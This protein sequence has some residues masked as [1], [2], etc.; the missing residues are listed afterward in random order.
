MRLTVHGCIRRRFE[1]PV[2]G[3]VEQ[4]DGGEGGPR[5]PD[6][7]GTSG[8]FTSTKADIEQVPGTEAEPEPAGTVG[9]NRTTV[10]S[11]CCTERGRSAHVPMTTTTLRRF[12]SRLRVEPR[13]MTTSH[14]EIQTGYWRDSTSLLVCKKPVWLNHCDVIK[15]INTNTVQVLPCFLCPLCSRFKR[16]Q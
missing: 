9:L 7:S 15:G 5:T 8:L 13:T 11:A 2:I 6:S 3:L 14:K 12:S 10:C 16:K 1:P 4:V